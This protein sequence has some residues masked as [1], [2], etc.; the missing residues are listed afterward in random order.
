M[1]GTGWDLRFSYGHRVERPQSFARNRHT[2]VD[3]VRPDKLT[4]ATTATL[5]LPSFKHQTASATTSWPPNSNGNLHQNDRAA[6]PKKQ[7]P[8]LPACLV[9]LGSPC[10]TSVK[11]QYMTA[12]EMLPET[13]QWKDFLKKSRR[14]CSHKSGFEEEVWKWIQDPLQKCSAFRVGEG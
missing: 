7:T 5:Q 9:I 4:P 12:R 11:M 14:V 10:A 2:S 13:R 8:A 6:T 1:Y 3:L